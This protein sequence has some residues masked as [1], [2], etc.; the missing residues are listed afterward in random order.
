MPVIQ[1]FYEVPSDVALGL[2]SGEMT[3]IGSV[4][5]GASRFATH[6]KEIQ[7]PKKAPE[8][9]AKKAIGAVRNPVVLVSITAATVAIG[10]GTYLSAQRQ[11]R[12]EELAG[13]IAVYLRAVREGQLDEAVVQAVLSAADDLPL[14]G[15]RRRAFA[16]LVREVSMITRQLAYANLYDAPALPD[17]RPKEGSIDEMRM[18]LESQLQIIRNAA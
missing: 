11:R 1:V 9:L 10:T 12:A 17:P 4:V 8:T 3:R 5:R 18:N 14:L 13:T 7:A 6:L 16:S 2:A 15:I